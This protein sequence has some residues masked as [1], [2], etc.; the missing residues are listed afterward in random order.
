MSNKILNRSLLKLAR[1]TGDE[2]VFKAFEAYK[3]LMIEEFLS[4]P[5]TIELKTGPGA[6]NISGTLYGSSSNG[7]LFTFIGFEKG[8]DPISPILQVLNQSKITFVGE[9]KK[10][11]GVKYRMH[12]PAPQDVFDVTPMPWASGRSWAKG[13]EQGISGLGRFLPKDN[14]GRSGG[15]IQIKNSKTKGLSIKFKNV[16]YITQILNNFRNNL[17]KIKL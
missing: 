7:N 11:I 4:H 6:S 5:V 9:N 16:P 10:R 2:L 8:Y 15:G 17:T 13:I 12:I 1:K 14:K 3:K